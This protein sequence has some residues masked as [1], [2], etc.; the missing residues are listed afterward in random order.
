MLRQNKD[1]DGHQ[2]I[3]QSHDQK[4]PPRYDPRE[5]ECENAAE[6]QQAIGHR[7][8]NLSDAADL[9]ERTRDDPIHAIGC[10][11]YPHHDQRR[12]HVMLRYQRRDEGYGHDPQDADEIGDGQI[13]VPGL[14]AIP[15]SLVAA[16]TT[17]RAD[18]ILDA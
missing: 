16:S 17:H 14:R 7:I 15:V 1:L 8:E 13:D 18:Q 11:G 12:N 5:A 3:A 2:A 6:Y 10:G 4:H 9:V